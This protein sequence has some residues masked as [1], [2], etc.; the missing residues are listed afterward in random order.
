MA[1]VEAMQRKERN[2]REMMS[3]VGE[4]SAQ[5]DFYFRRRSSFL[6]LRFVEDVTSTMEERPNKRQRVTYPL[7]VEDKSCLSGKRTFRSKAEHVA[8][9]EGKRVECA[10]SLSLEDFKQK[11]VPESLTTQKLSGGRDDSRK[12][13][14]HGIF[15][16]PEMHPILIEPCFDLVELTSK[17]D[18]ANS[19]VRWSPAKK[20]KEMHLP[21][22]KYFI[23]KH[24]P[25]IAG[26][27]S[28]MVTYEDG[29]EVLYIYE[30]H[31]KSEYQGKGLGRKLIEGAEQ[32]GRNVG[33]EKVMLT[34]FRS[35]TRAIGMYK[36]LGYG[37]DKYSPQPKV[38]RNGTPKESGY[39]ILSKSFKESAEEK[40]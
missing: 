3:F 30:I 35:N 5:R 16:N 37:V 4:S 15:T 6:G 13:H 32:I 36:R 26:F 40:T 34:V 17:D 31:L 24:G 25:L 22:M 18:Y 8:V 19:E 29:H 12:L 23:L 14:L 38:L 39:V 27:I 1:Y 33:L 10:N 7:F 20:K 2:N 21:D 28:M 11:F 9:D